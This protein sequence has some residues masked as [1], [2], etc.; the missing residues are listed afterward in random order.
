MFPI[1]TI[2]VYFDVAASSYFFRSQK[3]FVQFLRSELFLFE[4]P[5]CCIKICFQQRRHI[6]SIEFKIPLL[7]NKQLWLVLHRRFLGHNFQVGIFQQSTNLFKKLTIFQ[8]YIYMKYFRLTL[9]PCHFQWNQRRQ[10]SPW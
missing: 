5:F 9:P 10:Q 3:L 7:V 6:F 8:L 4:F 1:F 2:Q